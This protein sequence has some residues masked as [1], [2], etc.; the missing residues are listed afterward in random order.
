MSTEN[1]AILELLG[2]YSSQIKCKTKI[3]RITF[4]FSISKILMKL[5]CSFLD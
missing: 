4:V 2:F 3:L 5:Q 1:S